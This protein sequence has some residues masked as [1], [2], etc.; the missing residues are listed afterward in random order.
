MSNRSFRSTT[1]WFGVSLGAL[2]ER[3]RRSVNEGKWRLVISFAFKATLSRGYKTVSQGQT[4]SGQGCQTDRSAVQPGGYS[5][6]LGALLERC[7]RSVNEGKWR[8]VISF[9]F[10]ATFFGGAEA[11]TL[12]EAFIIRRACSFFRDIYIYTAI[13]K[14][15]CCCCFCCCC[16]HTCYCTPSK[17]YLSL[18]LIEAHLY[19]PSHE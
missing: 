1:W 8:L 13:P 14:C 17:S 5:V 18:F 9:A 4:S 2:L 6:S 3:C 11:L 16:S 7:R 10:K 19:G 12:Q 15:F